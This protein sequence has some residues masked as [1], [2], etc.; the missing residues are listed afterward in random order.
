MLQGA[1]DELLA[2]DGEYVLPDNLNLQ[3]GLLAGQPIPVFG[4]V[5]EAGVD[6]VALLYPLTEAAFALTHAA[7]RV[8]MQ[9]PAGTRSTSIEEFGGALGRFL[10]GV[11]G[12]DEIGRAFAVATIARAAGDVPFFNG[13]TAWRASDPELAG[14]I[15]AALGELRATTM[16]AVAGRRAK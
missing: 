13:D 6:R 1:V 16:F 9:A 10:G 14:R 12:D 5:Q 4:F 11:W 7:I 15:D 3:L 8:R 2:A